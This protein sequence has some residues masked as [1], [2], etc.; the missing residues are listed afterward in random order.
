MRYYF[1]GD[2]GTVAPRLA[3]LTLPEINIIERP[4]NTYRRIYCTSVRGLGNGKLEYYPGPTPEEVQRESSYT[5]RQNT[6]DIPNCHGLAE[7]GLVQRFAQSHPE[8]FA[9]RDDGRRHDGS[10]VTRDSDKTGQLCFSSA[11]LKEVIYEDAVAF[12]DR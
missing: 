6:I 3:Q 10:A 5:L 11:G 2:I 1:P 9:L 8:F 12:I 4:D 7:L